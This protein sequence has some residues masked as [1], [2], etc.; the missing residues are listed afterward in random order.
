MTRTVTVSGEKPYDVLIGS[1]LGAE[2]PSLIGPTVA[3]ILV[4]HPAS[5]E[6]HL[7]ALLAGLR[8]DLQVHCFQTPDA[9]AQK[10]SAILEEVWDLLGELAFTR[11]DLIIGL[12]GGATTDLAGFVAATWLRGVRW[13]AIPT[14]LAGMV[15]AAIGGKTGINTPAGKNLVGAFWAPTAVACDLDTLRTLPR[16]DVI[17]GLAEVIKTGFIADTAI[18]RLV[19]DHGAEL[20]AFDGP[21]APAHLIEVLAE[22]IFRSAAVKAA[23]VGEDLTEQGLREIL[24]YGHTFGHAIEQVEDYSWRHGEAVAV[25]MVFVAELARAAGLIDAGF[26]DQHRQALAAVGLPTSY[27]AGRWERLAEVMRRDKKTRGSLLRFVVL[28]AVAEPSRLEGPRA[29]WLEAA[30]REVCGEEAG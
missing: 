21:T 3:R 17:A 23:V 27:R 16:R 9:E 1:G 26:V 10:T 14:T 30:Y 20:R 8:P 7:P 6:P 5:V 19:A 4:I 2:I 24:N 15:D 12:G 11:T 25:G 28:T 13:L 29:E 22:L 18:L